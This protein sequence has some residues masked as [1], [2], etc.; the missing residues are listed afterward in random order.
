[1]ETAAADDG[2]VCPVE[3]REAHQNVMTEQNIIYPSLNILLLQ[4]ITAK[5]RGLLS[6]DRLHSHL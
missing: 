4:V 2:S 3:R 6:T 5:E 1:M